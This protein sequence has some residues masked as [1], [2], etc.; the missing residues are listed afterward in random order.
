MAGYIVNNAQ[1]GGGLE[2]RSPIIH[3]FNHG[4]VAGVSPLMDVEWEEVSRV[5]SRTVCCISPLSADL[6]LVGQ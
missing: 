6:H 2:Y 4:L 3:P 5:I 1:F